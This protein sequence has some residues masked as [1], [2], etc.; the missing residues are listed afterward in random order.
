VKK[1]AILGLG[2]I[3]LAAAAGYVIYTTSTKSAVA[4]NHTDNLKPRFVYA[5]KFVCGTLRVPPTFLG[6]PP[7]KPANYATAV[8]IHNPQ[9]YRVPMWKKAVIALTEPEQGRPSEKLWF[10]LGP[11][12]A[13]EADCNEIY[14]LVGKQ[15]TLQNPR[16]FV[17]GFLV[18]ES[19]AQLDVVGV[20]TASTPGTTAGAV[21]STSITEDIEY[22]PASNVDWAYTDPWTDGQPPQD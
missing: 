17:K 21:L 2:G 20:Y 4:E 22:I 8:N 7:V 15:P 6:E 13:T 3:A 11:D 10:K 12:H 5:A 14:K 19:W 16:P 9:R 18:I 1:L